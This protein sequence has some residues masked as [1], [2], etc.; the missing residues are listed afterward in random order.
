MM[1]HETEH[2]TFG[3]PEETRELPHGKAEILSIGDSWVV[4]D[5]PVVVVDCYGASNHAEGN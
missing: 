3:A 4:G 5:E 2:K 1:Q